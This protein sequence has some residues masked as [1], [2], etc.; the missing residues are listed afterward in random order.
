MSR[1]RQSLEGLLYSVAQLGNVVGIA[2]SQ[3]L[4]VQL[5]LELLLV[6]LRVKLQELR[7]ELVTLHLAPVA[8]VPDGGHDA[9]DE[10]GAVEGGQLLGRGAA[11]VGDGL[12]GLPS[13]LAAGRRLEE[14][15]EER[16]EFGILI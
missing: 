6:A 1:L 14:I 8:E 7:E 4:L 5:Q 3:E 16:R 12:E 13:E 11:D 10:P 15:K 2:E 9:V